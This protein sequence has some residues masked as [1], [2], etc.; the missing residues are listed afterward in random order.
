MRFKESF[1]RLATAIGLALVTAAWS[2]IAPA[3]GN[4]TGISL[5]EPEK[6]FIRSHPTLTLCIDPNWLPYEG[7]DTNGNH[8]GLVAEYML[9][10]QTRTGLAFEVVKTN[11]WEESW[12]LAEQGQCD[13]VSG[14]NRTRER[15]RYMSFTEDYINEPS[16]LVVRS[17]NTGIRTL[18]DLHGKRLAIVEGY[19][20]DEKLALDHPQIQ[21]IYATD[22]RDALTKVSTG[23]ADAAIDSKFVMET[24]LA[25]GGY[26]NVQIVGESGYLNLVRMG[27]R[28]DHYRGYSILNKAVLS[29]THADHKAIRARYESVANAEG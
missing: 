4:A 25:T 26:A 10:I 27:V 15:E 28:R 13:L 23:D 16:V 20:L 17:D 22:L 14:L 19:S 29:L 21:R 2:G 18:A 1:D 3:A 6:A 8:V 9:E 5:T 7:L 11:S 12:E 24:L